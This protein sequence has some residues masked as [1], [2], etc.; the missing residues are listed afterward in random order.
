MWIDT[1]CHLDLIVSENCDADLK[2]ICE[3]KKINF[4]ICPSADHRSFDKLIS[5]NKIN[6]KIKY[7]FGF[8]PLFLD[9]LCD[10]P[11]EMLEQY[12]VKFTPAAVGEIGLDFFHPNFN[13][14]KQIDFFIKQLD[15]ANKFS[16][17][18]ILHVRNAI[19]DVLNII[20]KYPKIKG[21]AH[22]FNGS[23]E[24][25]EK[26]ITM[27]FKLGFGGA[28][29]YDRAKKIRKL[30]TDLPLSSIVLE[31]DAPDMNPSWLERSQKNHPTELPRIGNFLADLR[32]IDPLDLAKQMQKNTSDIFCFMKGLHASRG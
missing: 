21:I 14:S 17:P 30:A 12:I 15:L 1:H 24:Q 16:L 26:F 29:T 23:F 8:H 4:I 20:K 27:N 13:K 5:Y 19:D 11:L 3:V 31:T 2:K 25:A 28:M 7:G 22:A 18:V 10:D 32:K 9:N 6:N